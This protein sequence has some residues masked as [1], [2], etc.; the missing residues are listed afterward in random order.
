MYKVMQYLQRVKS[1]IFTKK[2]TS[3]KLNK[4]F[5]LGIIFVQQFIILINDKP[6]LI[7]NCCQFI[8]T[9]KHTCFAFIIIII[10]FLS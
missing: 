3:N 1:Q 4:V 10:M 6:L 5:L 8:I 9:Q 2:C 7:C